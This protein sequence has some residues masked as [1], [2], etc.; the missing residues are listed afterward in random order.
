M[1]LRHRRPVRSLE[2]M[3]TV[4]SLSDLR[5]T[6][7]G[8]PG[9]GEGAGRRMHARLQ[10]S[11]PR[12]GK[13]GATPPPIGTQRR[14]VPGGNNNDGELGNDSLTQS[15]TPVAVVEPRGRQGSLTYRQPGAPPPP[16]VAGPFGRRVAEARARPPPPERFHAPGSAV[17]HRRAGANDPS[18]H[19]DIPRLVAMTVRLDSPLERGSLMLQ[20]HSLNQDDPRRSALPP[21]DGSAGAPGRGARAPRRR[22]GGSPAGRARPARPGGRGAVEGRRRRST[23][24]CAR[25]RS[26]TWT[27]RA[28]RRRASSP[29]RSACT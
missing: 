21:G 13:P 23:R 26:S 20:L 12:G 11:V 25:R 5:H 18:P 2:R 4:H 10:V 16:P 15:T 9:E 7:P 27:R 22:R 29:S 28:T 6:F 8:R 14:L 24:R 3:A 19:L 1:S 17:P